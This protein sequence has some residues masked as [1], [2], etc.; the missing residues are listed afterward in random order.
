MPGKDNHSIRIDAV[1]SSRTDTHSKG[2]SDDLAFRFVDTLLT[3]LIDF[4]PTYVPNHFDPLSLALT[5]IN[6]FAD[7]RRTICTS[8]S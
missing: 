6:M 7:P 5:L 2:L 8:R 1:A 3:V 4:P